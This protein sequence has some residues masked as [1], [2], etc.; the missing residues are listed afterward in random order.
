MVSTSGE[1]AG[2]GLEFAVLDADGRIRLDYI[3]VGTA[4]S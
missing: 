2:G 4:T 3:F 1:V